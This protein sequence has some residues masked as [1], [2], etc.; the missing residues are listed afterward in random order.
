MYIY[1]YAERHYLFRDKIEAEKIESRSWTMYRYRR[2]TQISL[3]R[4]FLASALARSRKLFPELFGIVMEF[5]YDTTPT[6]T[7]LDNF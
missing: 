3:S 7:L 1:V 6:S 5:Q 2:G 4:C